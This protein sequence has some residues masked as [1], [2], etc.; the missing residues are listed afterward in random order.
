MRLRFGKPH[1]IAANDAVTSHVAATQSCCERAECK[2]F[3]QAGLLKD[4]RPKKASAFKMRAFQLSAISGPIR[5][6]PLIEVRNVMRAIIVMKI[7]QE[8]D[9]TR[10]VLGKRR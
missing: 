4:R 8:F 7:G 6:T 10:W 1:G 3:H 2:S 5:R 9:R